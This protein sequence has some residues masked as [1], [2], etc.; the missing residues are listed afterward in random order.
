VTPT[1][2]QLSAGL[3]SEQARERLSIWGTN[4]V[5]LEPSIP[6]W[7]RVQR[8]LR[9][10]LVLVLLAA[11]VLT[12]VTSDWADTA[13]I[14]LVVIV[15]TAV[16][17]TQEIRADQAI[18]ALSRLSAP[19]ARAFRDGQELE[20]P[21]AELVPGDVVLLGEGDIVPADGEVHEAARLLIDESM[22]TGESVPVDKGVHA[23]ASGMV[24]A[25]TVVLRGR[26][27]AVV[28]DTG[29]RSALGRIAVLLGS[30][31]TD[32]PLQ[33]R[34]AGLGRTLALAAIALCGLVLLLGLA[35]GQPLELMFITAISLAVAAVP[36]SLPAVVT[37]S[38]ALSARRM[39]ARNAVIRRLPAVETLGSVTV[40][41][42][43]KTGTLTQG[44]MKVERLWTPWGEAEV[45]GEGYSPEGEIVD[46][47]PSPAR[48]DH[49][50]A[51]LRATVL[52]NDATLVGPRS[53]GEDWTV[54]G[55]PT[56]GALL[57][58]GS[59]AGLARST[60]DLDWP[61]VSEQPFES[62][63]GRMTTI[64]SR[65]D[66]GAFIVSKGSPEALL[67]APVVQDSDAIVSDASARADAWARDG[68][69]VLAVATSER[70]DG[71][72]D[73][74]GVECGLSLAG[75]VAILDPPR[76]SAARTI[77]ACRQ[78]GIRPVLVTGD[79][80]HTARNIAARLGIMSAG[81]ASPGALDHDTV[82]SGAELRAGW[83]PDPARTRVFARTSPE[84][85]LEIVK[86][87]QAAG[88]VVAMTGDGVNDGPALHAADIGVAMGRRG[89]EV[90]RQA[91]D[92]VLADDELGTVITAVEEGR[93]VYDNVRRFLLYALAG[94]SA[95]IAVMLAG[96]FLGMTLPL[97]PAQILWINLLTHGLPGVALGA[98]PAE[99]DVMR[100]TPRPPDQSVL[101][102][103]LWQQVLMLG[104]MIGGVTLALGSWAFATDRPWQSVV[105]VAL[106]AGQLGAALGARAGKLKSNPFLPQA[107]AG[108]MLLQLAALYV[109]GLR[110]LLGTDPLA[111]QDL[112]PVVVAP[113]VGY[114]ALRVIR[115]YTWTQR[116]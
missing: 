76:A 111:P 36:E 16:G 69:R 22:L 60:L 15:N 89:T 41:A 61:R 102:A 45:I 88:E 3:S 79:S 103:G 98:E 33:H 21:A 31:A 87:W 70:S 27:R 30:S 93:R 115:R 64:H 73:G 39:A 55:D 57:A 52:C 84:Q 38:L 85:K 14:L 4:T 82:V 71:L 7:R 78:A 81:E 77:A 35:R 1:P 100:R 20:L 24:S 8:Q 108:A 25:G 44:Q 97:L 23:D 5:A 112:A 107:V 104:F 110:E 91:A 54:L 62:S 80:P 17:V 58:A 53:S 48:P 6:I 67:H 56:E 42:T 47:A 26:A 68:Y 34:L 50:V 46:R 106:G 105:F 51:L 63:R 90:A 86:S 28:T 10:P 65:P 74:A 32:T 2:P 11:A 92:L 40:M 72:V 18:A 49:L 83:V 109:P 13:V 113:V 94:G 95:E 101:G 37:L 19:L 43:D 114:L 66:G 12:I 96:P 59:K 75:L 116:A 99:S 9:D 29:P